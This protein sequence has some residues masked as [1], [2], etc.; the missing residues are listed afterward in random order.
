MGPRALVLVLLV[1]WCGRQLAA[2]TPVYADQQGAAP[3]SHPDSQQPALDHQDAHSSGAVK[4]ESTAI[5]HVPTQ[6][7]TPSTALHVQSHAVNGVPHRSVTTLRPPTPTPPAAGVPQ[8]AKTV[9]S[10]KSQS[11]GES[12]APEGR[13]R[14]PGG[15]N[16]PYYPQRPYRPYNRPGYQRPGY[17]RPGYQ[18]P[19]YPSRY[20]Y[21]PYLREYLVDPEFEPYDDPA[22][23]GSSSLGYVL[24][25]FVRV[26]TRIASVGKTSKPSKKGSPATNGT[27]STGPGTDVTST[28]PPSVDNGDDS[29][30]TSTP[31]QSPPGESI[32]YSIDDVTGPFKFLVALAEVPT[33]MHVPVDPPV[34]KK[35]WGAK[36]PALKPGSGYV[37]V[38]EDEEGEDMSTPSPTPA[39]V[40]EE[41]LPPEEQ[42]NDEP[43]T[44]ETHPPVY[45]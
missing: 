42:G 21:R 18:R 30:L 22:Y 13:R 29:S 15:Y 44:P 32:F 11:A 12:A 33:G 37:G 17:Q 35:P 40:G 2:A 4:Q 10:Q 7:A 39:E 34:D 14:R 28:G 38:I 31:P 1:G 20:P 25:A 41:E 19:G 6:S 8:A 26:I 3:P 45:F 36:Q 16:R 9:A 24:D 27:T 23:R 5:P 43:A